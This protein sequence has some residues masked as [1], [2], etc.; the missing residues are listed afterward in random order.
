MQND[1]LNEGWVDK[2]SNRLWIILVFSFYFFL[3]YI[4]LFNTY[5]PELLYTPGYIL[6]FYMWIAII[7]R[8]I[9]LFFFVK[10]LRVAKDGIE[11]DFYPR[12]LQDLFSFFA[13]RYLFLNFIFHHKKPLVF[14]NWAQIKQISVG[15]YF[16]FFANNNFDAIR[17][18]GLFST[19]TFLPE[20]IIE[21]FDGKIYSQYVNDKK[22]LIKVIDELKVGEF[23]FVKIFDVGY[24]WSR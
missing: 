19:F 2:K 10:S 14:L 17:M 4:F 3:G 23:N 22:G 16:I 5:K 6:G 20:I 13:L 7:A 18:Y 15:T 8:K 1:I 24:R 11:L 21:T 12:I 9:N